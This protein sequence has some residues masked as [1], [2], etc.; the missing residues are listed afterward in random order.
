MKKYTSIEE[1]VSPTNIYALIDPR[2][3]NPY[4]IGQTINKLTCRLMGKHNSMVEERKQEILA[5]GYSL[6]IVLLAVTDRAIAED[7]EWFFI[8]KYR[9]KGLKLLN[10]DYNLIQHQ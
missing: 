5:D 8:R 10:I 3:N 7:L 9:M 6:K 4:Y 1:I 2:T